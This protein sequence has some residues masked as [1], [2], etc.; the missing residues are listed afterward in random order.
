HACILQSDGLS[1]VESYVRNSPALVLLDLILPGASGEEVARRILAF[2][3]RAKIVVFSVVE[4]IRKVVELFRLGISDYLVKPCGGTRLLGTVN[5]NI[6]PRR[7]GDRIE[8]E[9]TAGVQKRVAVA[10][11]RGSIPVLAGPAGIGKRTEMRAAMREAGI[12]SP[13]V[14]GV[15]PEKQSSRWI[16]E[17]FRM[18]RGK[19]SGVILW[20]G[21]PP[22]GGRSAHA[23]TSCIG[24]AVK[25][26][27]GDG[28]LPLGIT[29][30]GSHPRPPGSFSGIE[31][32]W[33]RFPSLAERPAAEMVSI[34]NQ[35]RAREGGPGVEFKSSQHRWLVEI[36]RRY[37]EIGT[38]RTM[39]A[40]ANNPGLLRYFRERI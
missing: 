15:F 5:G 7:T 37:P 23:L 1:A 40:L 33:I 24:E 8:T 28:P 38:M 32:E 35:L 17:G 39:R 3:P 34:L 13:A 26:R 9:T 25:I 6:R 30:D 21:R 29:W 27:K 20:A 16:R 22:S 19:S 14:L 18:V 4:S 11:E 31:A 36:L 10:L 12:E 2:D